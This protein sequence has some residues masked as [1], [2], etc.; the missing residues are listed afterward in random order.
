MC[1]CEVLFAQQAVD[2]HNSSMLFLT[3]CVRFL[4]AMKQ[5]QARP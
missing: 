5:K 2:F 4:M 1:V 3:L